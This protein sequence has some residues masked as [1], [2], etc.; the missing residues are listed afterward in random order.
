MPVLVASSLAGALL[1][2]LE[3]LKA[4]LADLHVVSAG[5]ALW[6]AGHEPCPARRR[7]W[8]I[9]GMRPRSWGLVVGVEGA[10]VAA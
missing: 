7:P 5:L 1:L 3:L 2:R 4:G 6:Y 9:V 10:N 8:S